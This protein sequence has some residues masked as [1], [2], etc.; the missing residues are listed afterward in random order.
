M[1]LP[2]SDVS[3]GAWGAVAPIAPDGSWNSS[4]TMY[5]S[6]SGFDE[7]PAGVGERRR[8]RGL[9]VVDQLLVRQALH[10]LGEALVR[11]QVPLGAVLVHVGERGGRAVPLRQPREP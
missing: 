8:A 10:Q 2:S 11:D 1:R 7:P 5:A 4:L 6:S 3:R 9:V